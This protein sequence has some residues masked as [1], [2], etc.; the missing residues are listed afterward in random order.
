MSFVQP[1]SWPEALEARAQHPEAV[2]IAGGTDVLVELNFGRL[3]PSALLDLSRV[4]ELRAWGR[5][6]GQ[7]RVGSGLTYSQIIADLG[8][9]L[10]A[11][12]MAAR[13]VGSPPVRNR[14]TI[15]GNLGSASPAGDCHPPLL[16]ARAEV[17]VASVNRSRTVPISEFFVGPKRSVLAPDELIAAVWV[18]LASG[19][20]VFAKVGTRNAMVIAVCS[21]ALALHPPEH[22]VGTGLGSVGPV[23]LPAPAA[24]Q[25][26]EGHL[27]E[28]GAWESRAP[29]GPS[30]LARFGQLVAQA[31]RPID[32][33]RGSAAYRRR[34]LEVLG[35]RALSWC[36]EEYREGRT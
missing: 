10:P 24:E 14:G 18:P 23:P 11:L 34:A 9:D 17:E 27:E 20:Q 1:T 2:A 8:R 22:R 31:A 25:F 36:W 30:V 32:D 13:T 19:P 3:R 7:I 15:G 28:T 12:T 29:L 21:F 16:A 33:V 35:R 4:G 26:L 5:E 6:D